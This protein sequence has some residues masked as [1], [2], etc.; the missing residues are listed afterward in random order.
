MMRK[1]AAIVA[2]VTVLAGSSAAQD[3]AGMAVLRG[4][5]VDAQQVP[6]KDVARPAVV[7]ATLE[8]VEALRHE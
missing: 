6:Q 4:R 2:V 5:V 1:A 3:T 8:P 7:A